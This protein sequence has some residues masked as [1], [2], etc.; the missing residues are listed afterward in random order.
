MD[1]LRRRLLPRLADVHDRDDTR[2]ALLGVLLESVDPAQA[3]FPFGSTLEQVG[4]AG[5]IPEITLTEKVGGLRIPELLDQF[6][7]RH[8]QTLTDEYSTSSFTGKHTKHSELCQPLI[9]YSNVFFGL[10]PKNEAGE[11]GFFDGNRWF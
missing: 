3:A 5:H 10:Q 11:A 9:E 1:L 8:W 4:I 2:S 6:I 7:D